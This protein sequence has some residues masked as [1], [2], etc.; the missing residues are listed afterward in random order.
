MQH[1]KKEVKGV[2]ARYSERRRKATSLAKPAFSIK[3]LENRLTPSGIATTT[4]SSSGRTSSPTLRP[5]LH[6]QKRTADSSPRIASTQAKTRTFISLRWNFSCA[7]VA[8]HTASTDSTWR[9]Q[10]LGPNVMASSSMPTSKNACKPL[11]R[12][13][14]HIRLRPRTC[15]QFSH[16][17]SFMRE[18]KRIRK[19]PSWIDERETPELP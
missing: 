15:N 11:P 8:T 12:N 6:S 18:C 17:V 7:K 2:K 5:S 13:S 3:L 14:H 10:T 4:R 16:L 19:G 1:A 9:L